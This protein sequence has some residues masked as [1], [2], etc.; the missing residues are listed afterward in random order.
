M[1]NFLGGIGVV[2]QM[3]GSFDCFAV[4]TINPKI[5]FII[6][7]LTLT[8]QF[9]RISVI[10]METIADLAADMRKST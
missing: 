2:K 6:E 8:L 5:I 10:P 3:R 4:K 9:S 1:T 7:N